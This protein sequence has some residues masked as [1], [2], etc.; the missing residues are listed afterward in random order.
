[1]KNIWSNLALYVPLQMWLIQG[2]GV[3]CLF[4]CYS[5]DNFHSVDYL[6]VVEQFRFWLK[7]MDQLDIIDCW[8]WVIWSQLPLM[9]QGYFEVIGPFTMLM[10]TANIK[11]ILFW[12]LGQIPGKYWNWNIY[13]ILVL[14]NP[15]WHWGN[16]FIN[17]NCLKIADQ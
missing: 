9:N 14:F 10:P 3:D 7:V 11:S 1:M 16:T 4:I 17:V 8:P 5:N 15:I 12:V 13:S 2:V 6:E